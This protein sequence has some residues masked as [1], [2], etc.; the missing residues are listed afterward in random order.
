M[1]ISQLKTKIIASGDILL[2]KLEEA[3]IQAAG[4][5][6]F[7]A[8]QSMGG[9]KLTNVGSPVGNTDASS[10]QYVDNQVAALGAAAEWKESVLSIELNSANIVSP[11]TGDRY[12]INGVGASDFLGHDNEIAEWNGSAWVFEAPTVGTYVSVDDVANGIYYFGGVSWTKKLFGRDSVLGEGHGSAGGNDVASDAGFASNNQYVDLTNT[13]VPAT[14]RVYLNTS[15]LFGEVG[16]DPTTMT[17][18]FMVKSDG[19]RIWFN[20]VHT[21]DNTDLI[22]ADYDKA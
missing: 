13:S 1:P 17:N 11:S 16:T 18:D 12:L 3:V 22:I 8:D 21:V 6:V 20:D 4:G 14:V 19:T 9:F 5:Q 15:R 10:K 7:T 2:T